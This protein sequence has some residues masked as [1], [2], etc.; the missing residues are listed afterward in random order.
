MQFTCVYFCTKAIYPAALG[1]KKKSP[2][3]ALLWSKVFFLK[4]YSKCS[5]GKADFWCVCLTVCG[6]VLSVR[7]RRGSGV[8]KRFVSE[9]VAVC[10]CAPVCLGLSG[11]ECLPLN[12]SSAGC[13]WVTF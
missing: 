2:V 8:D 13:V 3:G 6:S 1:E 10:L 5:Q 12:L 11:S 9:D 4:R 7:E